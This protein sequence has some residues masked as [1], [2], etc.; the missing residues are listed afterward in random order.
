MD[1]SL[2]SDILPTQPRDI[3]AQTGFFSPLEPEQLEKVASLCG[4]RSIPKGSPV[5]LLGDPADDFFVLVDGVVRFSL[6][7]GHA[8]ASAGEIIRCGDV[9]G[10]AALIEGTVSRIATAHCLTPC[11]VLSI[12]GGA[13]LSL[14]ESDNVLGYRLMKRLNALISG[15]LKHFVAG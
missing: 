9:F 6:R 3:I 11:T 12:D 14:M 2:H 10:W 15:N 5:Y 7:F 13:L 4:R 1:T 8:Q